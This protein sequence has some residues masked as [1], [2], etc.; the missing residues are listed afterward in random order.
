VA[1]ELSLYGEFV[2]VGSYL[3]VMDTVIRDLSPDT[4]GDRPWSPENSPWTAL[5]QFLQRDDRFT[6][7]AEV[8]DRLLATAAPNGYLIRVR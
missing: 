2:T 8:N 7:A 6:G 5:T 1:A 3:I 4:F